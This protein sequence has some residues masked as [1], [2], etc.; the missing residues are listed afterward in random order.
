MRLQTWNHKFINWE[1]ATTS[2]AG[3]QPSVPAW[4]LQASNPLNLPPPPPLWLE[5]LTLTHVT[6]SNSLSLCFLWSEL[7][8]FTLTWFVQL[9]LYF[10]ISVFFAY[11]PRLLKTRG[12]NTRFAG[13]ALFCCSMLLFDHL[14]RVWG[15]ITLFY[16]VVHLLITTHSAALNRFNKV[17][18]TETLALIFYFTHTPN[19][20]MKRLLLIFYVCY[21]VVYSSISF[22]TRFIE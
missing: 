7:L 4:L 8:Y 12:E 22:I 13:H 10:V 18:F 11:L 21:L 17:S 16:S 2:L 5:S 19:L 14:Y 1:T 9:F 6:Q 15:L 3:C 20:G